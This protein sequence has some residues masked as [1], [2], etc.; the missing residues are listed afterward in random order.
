MIS[1][2]SWRLTMI[3]S[4]TMQVR[5]E[6]GNGS[7][8]LQPSKNTDF[9]LVHPLKEMLAF[10]LYLQ[11]VAERA[12]AEVFEH[13]R[14]DIGRP[15]DRAG[16]DELCCDLVYRFVDLAGERPLGSC[17]FHGQERPHG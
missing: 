5:S 17:G 8:L 10:G 1:P 12:C 3:S 15:A 13:R 6:C 16:V 9:L 4:V 7:P 11:N 14:M 2:S